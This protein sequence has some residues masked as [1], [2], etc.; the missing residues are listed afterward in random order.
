MI[1]AEKIVQYGLPAMTDQELLDAISYKKQIGDYYQS[2]EFKAAKELQRRHE[3]KEKVQITCSRDT[4]KYMRFLQDEDY[5]QFW[6]IYLNMSQRVITS[7]FIC[8]GT[9]NVT[10]VNIPH[11]A[12]SAIN[13]NAKFVILVHNH[14][15]GNIKPSSHD[16]DITL[17]LEKAL[18]LFNIKVIDHVIVCKGQHFSFAD[19][20][21]I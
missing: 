10:T 21:I 12:K 19:E 8:K 7:E 17:Q 11:I 16:K 6:A 4:F 3:Y 13:H 5:E 1:A 14:P 9:I 15:S 20:G 2:F 18:N